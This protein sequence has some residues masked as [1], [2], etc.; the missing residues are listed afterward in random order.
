MK[1][2][3]VANSKND[4]YFT[5]LYAIKPITKFIKQNSTIWCP[6]DTKDSLYVKHLRELGHAVI[7]THISNGEDFFD[8][9]VPK[10]DY[11]ISNPPF[12]KK[13]QVLERLFN[14][15]IPFAMLVG[16]LGLFASKKKY[17]MFKNNKFELMYL[18]KR[19]S[20]FNENIGDKMN[21]PFLSIYVCSNVLPKQIVFEEIDKK[22]S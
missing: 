15:G 18:D 13:A 4:E 11:I 5:P 19:V 1:M 8:I 20:Y 12:S 21:P 2:H 22:I 16:D 14:I 10:C 7:N 6:F 17:E 9:D 3:T